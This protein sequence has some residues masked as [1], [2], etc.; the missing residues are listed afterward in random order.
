MFSSLSYELLVTEVLQG[1]TPIEAIQYNTA[2]YSK[3]NINQAYES[4]ASSF[5]K[6]DTGKLYAWQ[7][8]AKMG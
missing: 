1:Q 6:L 2:I 8:I 7:V 3:G 5:Y 4:Y